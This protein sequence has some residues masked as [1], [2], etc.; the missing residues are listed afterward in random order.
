MC[1]GG[2][3]AIG[4]VDGGGSEI[5]TKA[6]VN[7]GLLLIRVALAHYCSGLNPTR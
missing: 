4:G 6:M 2:I 7:T 3:V 5:L 1:G